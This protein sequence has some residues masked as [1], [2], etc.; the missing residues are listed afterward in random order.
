MLEC[1]TKNE[2]ETKSL[3]RQ[4]GLHLSAGHVV[5]V[6]GELGAGKTVFI[7]G[8]ASGMGV[9]EPVTSPSF[10]LMHQYSG[11]C[12][13]YHFDLYRLES[14]SEIQTLGIEEYL[15]TDGVA[16]LEWAERAKPIL[17]PN[18][19]HV[20]LHY[21]DEAP[22]DSR[23]VVLEDPGGRFGRLLEGMLTRCEYLRWI[24]LPI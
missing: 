9:S 7:Q 24:R 23:R 4:V 2:E 10:V 6:T 22:A 17:F 8:V 21:L 1:I 11:R 18:F 20:Q 13:V 16:L 3:G 19:L 15:W 5:G 14:S 12:P